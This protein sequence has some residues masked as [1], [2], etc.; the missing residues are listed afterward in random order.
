MA[1]N[2]SPESARIAAAGDAILTRRVSSVTDGRFRSLVDA[3]RA[4]DAGVVNLEV[5][6]H[7]YEGYPWKN[8]PGT[9]MRAPPAVADELSGMGFDLFAA[10]TNHALDYSHGGMEATMRE[11]DRRDVAYAGMGA[12]LS[13]AAAPA[14]ADTPAGRVALVSTCTTVTPGSEAG[15]QRPDLQGRPGIAPL[16]LDVR[17]EVPEDAYESLR[18]VSEA[19]GL[20]AEKDRLDELGFPIEGYGDEA[21]RLLTLSGGG[22][23]AFVQGE[24]FSVRREPDGADLDRFTEQLGVASRQADWVVASV[25]AHEGRGPT[26]NDPSV[27]SFLETVAHAAVDAGA[28]LFVGH[29]PHQLRGIEVYDGA[30]IFYS[31]GNLFMQNET[32][33]F[34][35]AEMYD[36]YDL[37]PDATPADVFDARVRTEDGERTGFLG[38]SAF[39]ES[40]LPVCELDS[41]GL[42]RVELYPLDLQFEADRPE[43]GRP[44]LAEGAVA[45]RIFDSLRELSEP[46][47]VEIAV[48]D[49][50]GV[51]DETPVGVVE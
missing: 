12:N 29:G 6:L 19:L 49:S 47:D 41:S 50:S 17:Y 10:A 14:Y 24:G 21:F 3:V 18:A 28:D 16:H 11:L 27:P 9:Y 13:R 46:Y 31:L 7:D 22:H 48:R 20:E 25:H 15:K 33:P 42:V 23:P 1:S 43:R 40:V 44:R 8:A 39:W 45:D 2:G 37:G 30:P 51:A 4:A 35:P 5:L 36:R 32:I 26:S 38:D 34:V